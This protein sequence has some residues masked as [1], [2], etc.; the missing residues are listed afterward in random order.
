MY[1]EDVLDW[2]NQSPG[3]FLYHQTDDDAPITQLVIRRR[4]FSLLLSSDFPSGPIILFPR[5]LTTPLLIIYPRLRIEFRR[6]GGSALIGPRRVS[7][8]IAADTDYVS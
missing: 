1:L 4:A 8:R 5:A 3:R 6:G 7:V 2:E